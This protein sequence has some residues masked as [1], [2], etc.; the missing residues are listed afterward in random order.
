MESL[1]KAREA[2][3]QGGRATEIHHAVKYKD[4]V[5]QC[6]VKD[7]CPSNKDTLV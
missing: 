7:P 3:P 2:G 1:S 4:Q 6:E 5:Q